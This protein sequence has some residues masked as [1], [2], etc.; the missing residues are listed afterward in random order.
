MQE[1]QLPPRSTMIEAFLARDTTYEGIFYTGVQ[2]TGIFCRPSCPARKPKPENVEFFANQREALLAGYRPCKRC[3]PLSEQTTPEWTTRLLQEIDRDPT[4]RWRDQ[5]LRELGLSPATVR[6]WFQSHYQMTFH[7]YSRARRINSAMGHLRHG[8]PVID[9]AFESGFESLSGFGEA[10]QKLTGRAPS[11]SREVTSIVMN[12]IQT[13]LGPMVAG[14]TDDAVVLL[15]FADRRMLPRQMSILATRLNAVLTP[16][17]SPQLIELSDQL[18]AYFAGRLRQFDTVIETPGTPFQNSV[19][20]QLREIPVG[21]TRS[22]SEIA[23]EIGQPSAARAVARANGDNR[24]AI[25]IPCHRV[26]GVNG[27]LSGYGGGVWRKKKLLE[28]EAR[29]A[30]S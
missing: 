29:S 30:S 4:R 18:E 19:W 11:A 22:Y 20:K 28:L 13:P 1:L 5:D 9:T 27:R 21:E 15:E 23:Q 26:I 10:F 2:T 17:A 14:A 24:I 25:L 8:N 7:A 12:R 6:R 3:T 16:G